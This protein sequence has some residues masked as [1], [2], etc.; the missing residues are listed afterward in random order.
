MQ[1]FKFRKFATALHSDLELFLEGLT[2]VGSL[3]DAHSQGCRQ[4]AAEAR[5]HPFKFLIYLPGYPSSF[6]LA[7]T[8]HNSP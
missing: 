3:Q 1:V 7:I 4:G 2:G 5:K 8:R 6:F